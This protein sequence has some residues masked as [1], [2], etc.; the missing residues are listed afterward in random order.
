MWKGRPVDPTALESG[1][2]VVVRMLPGMPSVA[3]RI[4]ANAGRVTGVI[5][6]RDR[7]SMLV[8]E[9][10]TTRR[11]AVLIPPHALGRLQVRFPRLEPGYLVDVIG[12]R[13]RGYLEA[14][15]PATSQPAYRAGEAPAR[16]PVRGRPP[17]RIAGSAVWH[18]PAGPAD[19]EGVRYPALDPETGCL[20]QPLAGI[21]LPAA[22][23]PVGR[24]PAECPQ[25]VHR[26]GA[27]AAGVRLRRDR[28]DLLRPVRDL[29]HLPPG[30]DR[31]PAGGGL[32][33]HGRRPGTGLLQRHGLAR[34]PG[35]AIA[36][37]RITGR[38]LPA[39]RR[40]TGRPVMTSP[41]LPAVILADLQDVQPPII[42]AILIGGCLAKLSRVLRSG[43]VEAGLGPTQLFP[44]GLRRPVAMI[45][46]AFEMSLGLALLV[47]E[48][49][50]GTRA[51][52][53]LFA[54]RAAT[55]AR[56][57]AAAFFLV[58][59]AALVELRGRRPDLGC[60]CFGDF[61]TQPACRRS[62]ARAVLLT[63]AALISIQAPA[64]YLPP[65][66]H[67]ALLFLGIVGAELA[68]IATLSPEVGEAL[69]R[70]GYTD[71]CELRQLPA[72]RTLAALRRSR[73]WRRH[74]RAITTEMPIDMWRELCWRYVVFPC[75]QD[76]E[77]AEVVFAV[78]LKRH[79]PLVQAAVLPL[80]TAAPDGAPAGSVPAQNQGH[81]EAMQ[82]SRH[83]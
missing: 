71:P 38:R 48:L 24:Q 78:Q 46:C 26:R 80:G 65:R 29:R 8:D 3:D 5:I 10:R 76:G 66:G 19:G 79:R 36:G 54:P 74:A 14:L 53:P 7:E 49:P 52:T 9:G 75:R 17:G 43:S 70:L 16:A 32:R 27:G 41:D 83:V 21:R 51:G 42:A 4:W 1:D 31:R 35:P 12:L 13:W 40:S 2:A 39:P 57:A 33:G 67:G 55:G 73:P 11:Q 18:E 56:I 61:S 81:H 77:N 30:P 28:P 23:V 69:V 6:E 68:L 63:G 25:R 58:A 20:E 44:L 60:G 37:T 64:L 47:T 82:L 45:M 59:A 50:V 15:V 34:L 72:G 22:A 62:L